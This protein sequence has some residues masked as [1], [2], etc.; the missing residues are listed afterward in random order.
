MVHN[1]SLVIKPRHIL[2]SGGLASGGPETH[3][4]MLCKV[5]AS[6]NIRVTIA[7]SA[8]NWDS[9]SLKA[10]RELGVAI[11]VP[12]TGFGALAPFGKLFSLICWPFL[13][14]HDY[15]VVY[16][17][18]HGR[19]HLAAMR[20]CGKNGR[21]IYHEIVDCPTPDS[22][23]HQLA[24]K[25]DLVIGNSIAVSQK[26]ESLIPDM[27]VCTIPFL[28]T[29]RALEVRSRSARQAEDPIRVAYL[30][31]LVA[32][33]R[34]SELI[35]LWGRI[36]RSGEKVLSTLSIY[37][38]D[39]GSGFAE[40]MKQQVK[41]SGLEDVVRICGTYAMTELDEILDS[42]D[43]VVLPSLYE[44]L[45]LVL[46]E[47]MIRGVPIVSTSA[48]GSA[49]FG[50]DNP[51]VAISK[52]TDWVTFVQSLE[53]MLQKIRDGKI[54]S[55]RLQ[56]WTELRYGYASVSSKWYEALA[57]TDRLISSSSS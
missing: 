18:G 4:S 19:M 42:T 23:V 9:R 31:R 40:E 8:T 53:E 10:L 46:V 35:E 52:G 6:K 54:N 24:A 43:L 16:C 25:M 27:P 7:A 55:H 57:M 33:K 13:L 22:A 15:D 44:G 39:Y 14:R 36:G 41:R 37:G 34:P 2:I 47:A 51:D 3:V 30:G 49:E 17:I 29:D 1:S 21:C 56:T 45:P 38:G 20:Y 26:I 5:L 11:V 12:P 28:T 48:G 50:I 32:H